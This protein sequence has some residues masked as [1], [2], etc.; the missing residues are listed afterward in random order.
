MTTY[1]SNT[2][3][4][5]RFTDSPAPSLLD[6]LTD[7]S[8][9]WHHLRLAEMAGYDYIFAPELNCQQLQSLIALENFVLNVQTIQGTPGARTVLISYGHG[10]NKQLHFEKYQLVWA[11][12]IAIDWRRENLDNTAQQEFVKMLF[13]H[14][15]P[16]ILDTA[17]DKRPCAD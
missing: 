1:Q 15:E 11:E 7:T 16:F 8:S 13:E 17:R 9:L 2:V 6:Q 4:A 14:S 12:G 3:L 5:R 10:S